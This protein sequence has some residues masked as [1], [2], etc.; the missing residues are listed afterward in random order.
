MSD[1]FDD[2][3]D[4]A[5]MIR[6]VG[7]SAD[8][9][10]RRRRPASRLVSRLYAAANWP[11][12]GKLLASL[13]RPLG[14]LGVAAIASG[15]FVGLIPRVGQD[16]LAHAADD[17]ARFSI[18]QIVELS[19]FVEQVD[20]AA[21]QNFAHLVLDNPVGLASFCTLIAVALLRRVHLQ[22]ERMR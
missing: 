15:A 21:L 4:T 11:L 3:I 18:D 10:V 19:D 17:V 12:R 9:E 22:R 20:P 13:L 1:E 6:G 8:L 14:P 2:A 16:G 5:L 7:S